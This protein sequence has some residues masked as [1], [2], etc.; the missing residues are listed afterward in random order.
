MSVLLL[1]LAVFAAP[2]RGAEVADR[3]A[4]VIGDEVI[5]LSEIYELGAAF[6]DEQCKGPDPSCRSEMERQILETLML[7]VLIRQELAALDLD[8]QSA[9]LDR[10]IDQIARENGLESMDRLRREVEVS[11]IAW[12]VYREQVREQLRQMRFQE[13]II[14]PR[15]TVTDDELLDLYKRSTRDYE[16]PPEAVISA[17]T[18]EITEEG[19]GIVGAVTRAGDIRQRLLSGELTWE[20]ALTEYHSGKFTGPGG[21]FPPMKKGE[22]M[23]ALDAVVFQTAEGQV[24]EPVV[25][26]GTVFLVK[27]LEF[28]S[29]GVRS[30]EEAKEQLREKVFA[31]KMEEQVEQWY[32]ETQKQASIRILLD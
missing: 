13:A 6:I 10:A 16:Q 31:A 25:V 4:A 30:F 23:P 27:V 5:A 21:S 20:D 29:S 2:A 9:D 12:D 8:I 1:L 15:I 3:I 18:F 7:R 28:R 24:A 14:R 32:L 26:A 17:I 11:G 22:L 19:G